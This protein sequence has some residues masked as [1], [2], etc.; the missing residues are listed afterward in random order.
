MWWSRLVCAWRAASRA[1]K[2]DDAPVHRQRTSLCQKV[3]GE[4]PRCVTK[5]AKPQAPWRPAAASRSA[6]AVGTRCGRTSKR[7]E[8][9]WRI[10]ASPS[11]A[12]AARPRH[13]PAGRAGRGQLGAIRASGARTTWAGTTRS[14]SGGGWGRRSASGS[15]GR[16]PGTSRAGAR[17]TRGPTGR[18][19][20]GAGGS[21]SLTPGTRRRQGRIARVGCAGAATGSEFVGPREGDGCAPRASPPR[22][23]TLLTATTML[24]GGRCTAHRARRPVPLCM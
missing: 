24:A 1:W 17:R 9:P 6:T 4:W 8:D 21:R 16:T 20:A 23:K 11:H 22:S 5:P 12:G 13:A 18:A 7:G 14:R 15:R 10:A 3:C 2:R 19:E